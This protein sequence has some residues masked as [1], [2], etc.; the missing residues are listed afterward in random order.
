MIKRILLVITFVLLL[1]Q[2]FGISSYA[3]DYSQISEFEK[4]IPKEAL[5]LLPDGIF[6]YGGAANKLSPSY[7][8]KLISD[9]FKKVAGNAVIDLG[10]LV[11]LIIISSLMH[12]ISQASRVG[13]LDGGFSTVSGLCVCISVFSGL[14]KLFE[15][16]QTYLKT[17]ST[18][19]TAVTPAVTALYVIGGNITAGAVGRTGLLLSITLLE[20]INT[21]VLYPMLQISLVLSLARACSPK[22]RI[23]TLSGFLKGVLGTGLGIMVAA[24]SAIMTFQSTLAGAADSLSARAVKFAVSSFIP[25]VGGAVSE[26]V[27]TV[28]AS[29][30]YI[31]TTVGGI[32][33]AV[34][35]IIALPPFVSLTLARIS[36]AISASLADLL[37]CERECG[38]IKEAGGLVNYLIALV[39][40]MAVLFIYSMTVL[41]HCASSYT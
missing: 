8:F 7:F 26:A 37:G 41:A 29:I 32:G 10:A 15:M 20:N 40:L 21:R 13:G 35:V 39:S 1:G 19:A 14:I 30:S 27:R 3:E 17:L 38:V 6:E 34:I 11:G 2:V 28:S 23:N 18:F 22:L 12:N 9:V 16:T 33:V 31:R 24:L 36:L 4:Y 5:E 25:I